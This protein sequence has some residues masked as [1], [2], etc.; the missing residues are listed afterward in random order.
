[1]RLTLPLAGRDLGVGDLDGLGWAGPPSH[2]GYVRR[3]LDRVAAGEAAYL[4]VCGPPD[5]PLAIGAA[6]FHRRAGAGTIHQLAVFPALQSCGL[7]TLLI[8]ALEAAI[9]EQGLRRADLAVGDDNVRARA[10]Y[11]RL[12]YTPFGT[13]LDRWDYELVDG[14]TGTHESMC[15]LLGKDL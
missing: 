15:T 6:D 7:G 13:E 3:E 8:G 4:A 11:E 12:G 2:V 9:A 1:M 10:L 14:T 5:V